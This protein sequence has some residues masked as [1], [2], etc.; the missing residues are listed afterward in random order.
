MLILKLELEKDDDREDLNWIRNEQFPNLT[1]ENG[2][3]KK[4]A[5]QLVRLV[6]EV[7]V[8]YKEFYDQTGQNQHE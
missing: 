3:K 6:I 1:Y 2:R 7:Q 8:F 5:E 4:S